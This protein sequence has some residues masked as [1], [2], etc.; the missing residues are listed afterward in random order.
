MAF[1]FSEPPVTKR[2]PLVP[3]LIV[4]VDNPCDRL[5]IRRSFK[6][7]LFRFASTLEEAEALARATKALEFYVY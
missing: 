7:S 5:A 3:A 2:P 4:V 1:P 6:R